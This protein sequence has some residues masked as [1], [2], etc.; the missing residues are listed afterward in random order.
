VLDTSPVR[1]DLD[2]TPDTVCAGGHVQITIT[3]H[4]DGNDT[5]DVAPQLV[6]TD[7][8]P[9]VTLARLARIAVPPHDEAT[10]DVDIIVPQLPP[11]PYRVFVTNTHEDNGVTI[12]M[13]PP[14]PP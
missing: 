6:I 7:V 5:V 11:G 1:F 4:N 10:T 2:A 12:T 3:M 13:N 9:H 8:L 14:E